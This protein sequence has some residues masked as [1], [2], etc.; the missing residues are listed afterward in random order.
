MAFRKSSNATGRNRTPA[1]VN[2][3]GLVVRLNRGL[4]TQCSSERMRRLRADCVTFRRSAERVKLRVSAK[5]RKS[6]IHRMS[7]VTPW[8]NVPYGAKGTRLLTGLGDERRVRL[9]WRSERRH[10]AIFAYSPRCFVLGHKLYCGRVS[11]KAVSLSGCFDALFCT[12]VLNPRRQHIRRA[13]LRRDRL[14]RSDKGQQ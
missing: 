2:S 4:P 5:S 14:D 9:R 12:T 11:T 3:T 7:T 1:G 13:R 8:L 10:Y 6:P